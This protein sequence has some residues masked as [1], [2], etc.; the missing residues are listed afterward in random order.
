[1]RTEDVKRFMGRSKDKPQEPFCAHVTEESAL[2]F[3]AILASA[4]IRGREHCIPSLGQKMNVIHERRFRR[5]SLLDRLRNK[6]V[7][8]YDSAAPV[9]IGG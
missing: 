6:R 1:L 3:G 5:A 7:G 2:E 9:I 8:L 4:N